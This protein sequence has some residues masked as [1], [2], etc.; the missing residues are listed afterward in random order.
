MTSRRREA[1][2]YKQVKE[3]REREERAERLR[4]YYVAMTRA[5]DRLIV[6]GAVD[7]ESAADASTPMGWV[8]GRLDADAELAGGGDAPLELDR[9][10]ARISCASTAIGRTPP[11]KR[12]RSRRRSCRSSHSSPTARRW[13]RSAGA[14]EHLS[15]PRRAGA[16]APSVRRLSFTALSPSRAARTATTRSASSACRPATSRRRTRKDCPVR[17][18][19]ASCTPSSSVSRCASPQCRPELEDRF[20]ETFRARPR[21]NAS[22]SR[23]SCARIASPTSPPA[24]PRSTRVPE[25]T[26]RSSTTR[27]ASRVPRRL[28]TARRARVRARLQVDRRR[29][30]AGGGRRALVGCSGWSTRSPPAGGRERGRGVYHFLE[31]TGG[32]GRNHVQTR[33]GAAAR[34]RAERS[35]RRD[36]AGD[37]RPTPSE[38]AWAGCPALDVV[39]AGPRLRSAAPTA[40]GYGRVVRVAGPL[41]HPRERC[42]A[43]RRARRGGAGGRGSDRRRRRRRGGSYP[44]ETVTRLRELGDRVVYMRGTPTGSSP[45]V[46]TGCRRSC[47]SGCSHE[48]A[49]LCARSSGRGP[50]RRGSMSTASARFCSAM[51]RRGTTRR[52]SPNC[53]R[54]SSSPRCSRPL[55]MSPSSGTHMQVDRRVGDKRIVNA[56]SI[57]LPYEGDAAAFWVLLGDDVEHRRTVYDVNAFVERATAAGY[58]GRVLPRE[59]H[60]AAGEVG[61]RRVLRRHRARPALMRSFVAEGAAASG[62]NARGSSRS[63]TGS[64]QSTRTRR[65]HSVS[66]RRSSCSCR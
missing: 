24:S 33:S 30:D 60:R 34:V 20:A 59:P 58:P 44:E 62:R 13:A 4:L 42:G 25:R 31:L 38:Y 53:R 27:P 43:R 22:A 26:S 36:R 35:D 49:T 48:R 37:F 39:C 14:A 52:S 66:D 61:S 11:P 57:G 1:F 46:P 8:L 47:R 40:R 65:S 19:A 5:I 63:S 45:R 17:R 41:R 6:S 2:A 29:G 28:R 3:A 56:G 16:A 23:R 55:L 15:F 9:D 54:T 50:N 32:A 64:R 51:R 21:K 10:E 12:P 18:S 7:R